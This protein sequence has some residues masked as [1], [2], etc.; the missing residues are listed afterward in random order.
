MNKA[1]ERAD[2]IKE[3]QEAKNLI[4][5]MLEIMERKFIGL[6]AECNAAELAAKSAD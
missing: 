2:F 4:A 6:V 3:V 5:D 1:E